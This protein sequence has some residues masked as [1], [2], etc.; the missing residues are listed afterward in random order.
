[1]DG[2]LSEWSAWVVALSPM[3]AAVVVLLIE[4]YA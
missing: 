4:A 1:M 2:C 3:I